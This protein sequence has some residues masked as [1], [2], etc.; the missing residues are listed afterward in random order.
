MAALRSGQRRKRQL[1][2]ADSAA[3]RRSAN[4][5]GAPFDFSRFIARSSASVADLH[6]RRGNPCIIVMAARSPVPKVRCPVLPILQ[7][8]ALASLLSAMT[9]AALTRP[10]ARRCDAAARLRRRP[11]AGRSQSAS[12]PRCRPLFRE[13]KP[14]PSGRPATL[15]VRRPGEPIP[16]SSPDDGFGIPLLDYGWIKAGPVGRIVPQRGTE[17]WQ[18]RLSTAFPM[19]AGR[20]NLASSANSGS[21]SISAPAARCAR[22][23]TAMTGSTP[24]SSS[25]PCR[26][27]TL[28]PSPSA[29]ACSFG[30]TQYMNAYFSVTPAQAFINGRVTPFQANGGL[31]SVGVLGSVKYDFMPTWSA[32]VFGGYNRLVSS[33]AA[34]PIPNNLGSL[35]EFSAGVLIAHTFNLRSPFLPDGI[36]KS[37]RAAGPCPAPVISRL[38]QA[39]VFARAPRR[40]LDLID[41]VERRLE[42]Q[43]R[44]GMPRL[45]VA[46]RL[47]HGDFGPFSARRR[48]ILLQHRANLVAQRAQFRRGRADDMARHDRGGRLTQRAG[49]HFMSKINDFSIIHDEVDDDR[50]AAKLRMR[51]GRRMR[52][53]QT[54]LPGNVS[55]QIKDLAVIYFVQHGFSGTKVRVTSAQGI[56]YR[57]RRDW[58]RDLVHFQSILPGRRPPGASGFPEAV[59]GR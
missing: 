33:A 30:D 12:G 48:A 32:T 8:L 45:I 52:R 16:F 1:I 20:L 22:A 11:R 39:E 53:R 24:I 26:D 17:Q 4:V 50:R 15:D 9:S 29:R 40:C 23:S 35:N 19:S 31:A 37:R 54:S 55:R 10:P 46:D 51:L 42:G 41:A 59:P 13:R 14:S 58:R 5:R 18:R 7:R 25:T 6:S 2:G 36:R 43:Q 44:R 34:S 38:S 27:G 57:M 47:E 56:L 49:L 21:P 3:R 28:S